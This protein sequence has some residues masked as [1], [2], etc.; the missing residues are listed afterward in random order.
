MAT[1]LVIVGAIPVFIDDTLWAK[2]ALKSSGG[3]CLDEVTLKLLINNVINHYLNFE[4]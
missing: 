1:S 2:N 3:R 4:S